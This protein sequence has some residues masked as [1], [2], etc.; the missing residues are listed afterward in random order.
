MNLLKNLFTLSI[1]LVAFSSVGQK[2]SKKSPNIIF[3]LADDLGYGDVSS[4]N[5]NSK[6]KTLHIDKL[7][8][9]GVLFTDA[10]TS[11]S[12]CTPTRYGILTGRYNWRSKLKSGVIQ[13]FS[14]A[15]IPQ[16]RATIAGVLKS[17]GYKT[18]AIGKWHLGWDWANVDEGFSK[19][20]YSKK[21]KNGPTTLGFDYWFGFNGS[22]DMAPYVWV[23]NDQPTMVPNKFTQNTGQAMWRKGLTSDDFDHEQVLPKVTAKTVEYIAKNAHNKKPF[24][25]Y[26]PLPAPHTPI[27]PTPEFKGKSGLNNPYGDFVLMVDSVV[28]QVMKALE[29]QGIADNTLVVFTSDNGCSPKADFKQLATKNHNPSYVYRGHKADIFEGGHRVP[30]IVRWPSKVKEGISDQLLCTT[31]FFATVTDA[32]GVDL[33]DNE[34]EDSFSFLSAL[35]IK[36]KAAVRKSIVHHSING[37]FAYR[38]NEWKA[39]FCPGSGGWS[40]PRFNSKEAKELPKF[41]LYNLKNDIGEVNNLQDKEPEL[42]EQYRDELAQIVLNGRSTVGA[43][44][45]NDGAKRW[46]QL[47]W[48][49]DK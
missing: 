13:G 32:L 26:M 39:A 33:K 20:D 2:N 3:I 17:N 6:I 45:K 29:D 38:K 10:H 9:E 37:S 16:D 23:E 1:V 12:V 21:I 8:S 11:S 34:A 5:K 44:Q 27:L 47:N 35:N 36:S 7:A 40:F 15:L 22:L 43:K 42:L 48:M 24:F 30:F 19:V 25:L 28:G 4:Y 46:A 49:S 14:K 31:D 41:Q 18:A